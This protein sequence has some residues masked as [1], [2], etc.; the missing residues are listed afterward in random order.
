LRVANTI[1][2][3]QIDVMHVG[4]L[5]GKACFDKRTAKWDQFIKDDLL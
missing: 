4:L 1:G 5:P 3:T 2:V